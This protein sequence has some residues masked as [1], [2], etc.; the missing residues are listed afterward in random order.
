MSNFWQRFA[1]TADRVPDRAAIQF[2]RRQTVDVIDYRTLQAEAEA[3]AAHLAGLG[4]AQKDRC[5]ILGENSAA[6]CAAYLGIL[7]LGA[8]AVPIDRT[9]GPGQV[10]TLMAD[11]GATMLLASATCRACADTAR[12][13]AQRPFTI[14]PL[15]WD[16]GAERADGGHALP[17]CPARAEDPA[18]I[19]YTSGTTS[20]P[21][22]V[23][24][25]HGNI[26]AAVDG[27]LAALPIGERDC[28]LGA[29]PLFHILSQISGLLLPFAE[30]GCV[31]MLEEVNAGEVLR[32]LRE[33]GITALCSVPQFFYLIHERITQQIAQRGPA[34]RFAVRSVMALSGLS[35]RYLRFNLGAVV[36][37]KVHAICGRDMRFF[38]SA[39]AAFDPRVARD[40]HR[41]GFDI[42][43]A[44]GLTESTGAATV[45]SRNDARGET[46][47]VPISGVSVRIVSPAGET[48]APGQ[49]GEIALRG[50]TLTPG[51]YRRPE[52]TAAAFHDGWFMTGDLGFVGSDGHL[53]ISG[54]SKDVIILDSGKNI[55]PEEIERHLEHS[56]VI[57]E[58]CVIG[59]RT[60]TTPS[61]RLFAAVVPDMTALRQR[62]IANVRD[63]LRNEI[64]TFCAQL[65]PHKR[66]AGFEVMLEDLPRT[67]T[68]KIKRF[69]VL[70][71][72]D[73][74]G[75]AQEGRAPRARAYSAEDR[76]WADSPAVADIL[77]LIRAQAPAAPAQIHPDDSLDLDLQFDSLGRIDLIVAL[78]TVLGAKLPDGK[79]TEC[80]TVRDL[81]NALIEVL[82]EERSAHDGKAV[83]GWPKV[84]AEG[85][86]SPAGD[87]PP[88]RRAGPVLNALRFCVLKAV[89]LV[90]RLLVRLNVKGAENLPLDGPFLLCANHQS[91]LDA[92][93]LFSALPHRVVKRTMSLGKTRVF[94]HR[95]LRWVAERYD[96][97]VVDA[98]SNLVQAMQIS[99]RAL[100]DGKALLLF[101]EGERSLDGDIAPL[102]RGAAVLSTYMKLPIVPVVIEGPYRI[103]PRGR[104]FQGFAPVTI[105]FLPP[106]VPPTEGSITDATSF[107]RATIR[108]NEELQ[109][110]MEAALRSMR[111]PAEGS[112]H[113]HRAG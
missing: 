56:S 32:A 59:R 54:R 39:G 100:R 1:A 85:L 99:A 9:Y 110:R 11:S 107:D 52:A 97:A 6:W 93:L 41:L 67:T 92:V 3:Y 50:P 40:L 27:V 34:A 30:G 28:S 104:G 16:P 95:G 106:L 46:V 7:R 5:A 75:Q 70:Q 65:P 35:R 4:L 29:L 108:L 12:E 79:G 61:E 55:Y 101:P 19:L 53:R 66:V 84:L 37:R 98:D 78:E 103:W 111:S 21:K 33:R 51:Y 82:P 22:G 113:G 62:R 26:L 10:E 64:D 20:D 89:R 49:E 88:P 58:V 63:Y 44:Y 72:L 105:A 73:A 83:T 68:R 42:L 36:F 60:G 74:L 31:V 102:R 18:V 91:Y 86:A 80:Y 109:G 43:Q 38:L 47:G 71:Q 25:T 76:A 96:V 87:E 2:Q 48:C 24:L 45:S 57:K 17:P 8:I 81:A 77:R 15:V 112:C 23:V 69:L 90:A 14:A 13:R 94:S